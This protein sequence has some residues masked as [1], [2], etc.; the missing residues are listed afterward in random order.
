MLAYVLDGDVT[1]AI[2]NVESNVRQQYVTLGMEA[3][4]TLRPS[5]VVPSLS[6]A[7]ESLHSR[8]HGPTPFRTHHLFMDAQA[9]RAEGR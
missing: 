4:G 1:G 2:T 6:M 9:Q 3:P 8:I 5:S 7:R